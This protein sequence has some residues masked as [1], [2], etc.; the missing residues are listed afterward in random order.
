MAFDGRRDRVAQDLECF[1]VPGQRANVLDVLLSQT[2][3][4]FFSKEADD[5]GSHDL[6]SE[7]TPCYTHVN[8]WCRPIDTCDFDAVAWLDA[9]DKIIL[10]DDGDATGKLAWWSTFRHLLY[11]DDLRVL[12]EAVAIFMCECITIFVSDGEGLRA[13]S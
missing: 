11:R 9:I 6:S 7:G 5:S 3:L 4:L 12:I 13:I 10:E 1:L 2:W 8:V